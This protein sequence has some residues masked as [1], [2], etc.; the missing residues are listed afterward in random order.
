MG[1]VGTVALLGGARG[2]LALPWLFIAFTTIC[3][4]SA[5]AADGNAACGNPIARIVSIQGIVEVQTAGQT[6][7]S[8]VTRLDTRLCD[9]DRLRTGPA[10]RSALFL[11]PESLVRIDRNTTISVSQLPEETLVEFFQQD[12]RPAASNSCGAGY[13]ISRFPRKLKVRSPHLSAAV[14]GTEFLVAMSCDMDQ[15]SVF[16]GNVRV[17]QLADASASVLLQSGQTAAAGPGEAPA[18]KLNIKPKDAVQ[19]VVYYPPL[20]PPDAKFD[21]DCRVVP[22]DQ[23]AACLIARAEQLLRTG[24]VDEA[25]SQINDALAVAPMSSD[26]KALQSILHLVR[27]EKADAVRAAKEAVDAS[28]GS[29]P[30]WIALSYAQ[31]ADFKLEAALTSAHRAMDIAPNN[32]LALSR[33]AEIQLSLGWNREAE[34]TALRAVEANGSESRAHMILG[35][36]HLAQIKVKEAREDFERAI[37]IDS[38]QPLSRLGLGLAIIR[39]G[40]LQEGREQIEIAVA[41]DPTN[42]L[43]RS[44]VGKAYYEE[45]STERDEL[46]VQQFALAKQLDPKDPTPWFYEAI[47][48]QSQNRLPE[49]MVSLEESKALNENRSIFRSRLAIDQDLAA[50]GLDLARTYSELGFP[51]AALTEASKATALDPSNYSAHQFLAS[52]YASL[53]KHEI[54]R[55]SELL[56]SRLREPPAA[57]SAQS[58]ADDQR[59]FSLMTTSP[60]PTG[61]NEYSRLFPTSSLGLFLSGTAGTQDTTSDR[62]EVF[63]TGDRYFGS[64][65][66]SRFETEGLRPNNSYQDERYEA[67]LHVQ[68][69]QD[70]KISLELSHREIETGDLPLRFDPNDWFDFHSTENSDIVRLGGFYRFQTNAELLVSA[71][72]QDRSAGTSIPSSLFDLL[73]EDIT[74]SVEVQGTYASPL[75]SLAV[76]T[77]YYQIEGPISVNSAVI[78]D[79]KSEHTNAYLYSIW[80]LLRQLDLTLGIS[81]D[82]SRNVGTKVAQTNPKIGLVLSVS[83][84]T[85]LRA[86][87][88]RTFRRNLVARATIEPAQIAGFNQ[89][90]DDIADTDARFAGIG[91]DHKWLSHSWLG[92]SYGERNLAFPRLNFPDGSIS[93]FRWKE[94]SGRAYSYTLLS[95]HWTLALEYSHEELLRPEEEAGLEGVI[96]SRTDILSVALGAYWGPASARFRISGAAQEGR[97]LSSSFVPYSGSSHFAVADLGFSYQLPRRHGF[98]AVDVRNLFDRRFQFQDVDPT[99]PRVAPER[100]AQARVVVTF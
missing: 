84:N 68:H 82:D 92:L 93:K 100:T 20:T 67:E 79:S 53:P 26:A 55:Q 86:A 49:A 35:F 36:V 57:M 72:Y 42:S 33:V 69:A 4:S 27:N 65:R 10:G 29:A 8:R 28:P 6:T 95:R 62:V 9:G 76:G 1:S 19:W 14:E 60:F 87:A 38:T 54:A 34:K 48:Q 13:F 15:V 61:L 66:H 83:Q 89:F 85:S 75:V 32:A 3:G 7:W 78:D 45:N 24:H 43:L 47:L 70:S 46:A 88:F 56:Q 5:H 16:E 21:E 11:Q 12:L 31:Q 25:R 90:F 17:S 41:L 97:F 98:L 96:S 22:T 91:L 74:E 94:K 44:Y 59:A 30:A 64:V 50:R 23:R 63:G 39:K 52:T 73:E 77:G 71:A 40:K 99:N 2:F 80:H 18:I 37:E 58:I 81:H 51:G